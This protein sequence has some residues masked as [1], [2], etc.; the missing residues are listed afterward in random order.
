MSRRLLIGGSI[1]GALA[2]A[3]LLSLAWTPGRVS[4][5]R[6]ADRLKAPLEAGLLGTDQLGRD[7][8]SL[9]MAGAANSLGI[10][11]AAVAAGLVAGAAV[12]LLAAARGG[13]LDAALM[14]V[15]DVVFAVPPILSAMMLAAFLGGGPE[16]A[17]IAIAVFTVP[18][19]ARVAR[20]GAMRVLKRDFVLAARGAGKSSARI[21]AEHVAPN[22][23]GDLLVQA[24]LQLGL[25]ILT[26]AGLSFLGLGLA[27]PA[28]SWG[29]MLAD[30]QTF[31]LQ[32][33][34]LA[35]APGLAIA[36]AVLG[37]NLLGDGLRDR[38]DPRRSP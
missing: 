33:P 1:V 4:G 7:V 25:A 32:A 37:F 23:A 2:G 13:I 29:R 16:T 38:F 31:F 20:A 28:P 14:R 26:E 19:F 8:L 21:A 17:T 18:V 24:T 30:S 36:L 6:V 5:F 27:P 34:W 22:V 15:M 9:L 10:A 3:G 11:C 12:G 35:L